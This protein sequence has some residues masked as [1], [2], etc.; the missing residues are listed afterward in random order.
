MCRTAATYSASANQHIIDS[1]QANSKGQ[2]RKHRPKREEERK[3]E[4]SKFSGTNTAKGKGVCGL[5]SR[6][7]GHIL[8][9]DNAKHLARKGA[10]R[11]PS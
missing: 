5:S 1:L 2:G 11:R 3:G 9:R 6:R 8:V 7:K 10:V 4:T